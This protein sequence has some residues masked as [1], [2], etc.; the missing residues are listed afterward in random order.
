MDNNDLV[1][2]C[3]FFIVKDDRAKRLYVICNIILLFKFTGNN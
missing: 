3:S 1:N 2:L